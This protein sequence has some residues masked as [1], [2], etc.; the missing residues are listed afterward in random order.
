MATLMYYEALE[1]QMALMAAWRTEQG[2][3]WARMLQGGYRQVGQHQETVGYQR[4]RHLTALRRAIPYFIDAPICRFIEDTAPEMP[5]V[6]LLAELVPE[7]AAFVWL[8]RPLSLGEMRT[9]NAVTESHHLT[10]QAVSWDTSDF[11]GQK[12]LHMVFYEQGAACP[13]LFSEMIWPCGDGWGSEWKLTAAPSVRADLDHNLV[14]NA[15]T[16]CRRWTLA[17]LNFISQRLLVTSHHQ[18]TDRAARRRIAKWGADPPAVRVVLLR[19]EDYRRAADA[20][21]E[22]VKGLIYLTP[23]AIGY[24]MVAYS[25]RKA[26]NH[27]VRQSIRPYG[28]VPR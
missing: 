13:L 26:S 11:N 19:K 6:P 24:T 5:N 20:A 17:F 2:A 25:I 14:P 21:G 28:S 7:P 4:T 16:S 27:E 12:G 10:L 1:K 15:M 23:P 22:L 3:R 18:V 9:R 8:A